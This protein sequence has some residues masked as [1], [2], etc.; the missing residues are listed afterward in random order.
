M[1]FEE[2]SP[3][4]LIPFDLGHKRLLLTDIMRNHMKRIELLNILFLQ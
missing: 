1:Y 4:F 2:P 3:V